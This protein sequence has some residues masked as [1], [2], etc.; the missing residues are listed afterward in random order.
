MPTIVHHAQK[1]TAEF[2]ATLCTHQKSRPG[3]SSIEP[4]HLGSQA[5]IPIHSSAPRESSFHI[6]PLQSN[7]SEPP[8]SPTQHSPIKYQL[9]LPKNWFPRQPKGKTRQGLAAN[10]DPPLFNVQRNPR[11]RNRYCRATL[12]YLQALPTQT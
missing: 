1:S 12:A 2:R 11:N 8:Q 4:C 5:A 3:D 10:Q 7:P 9:P 6:I